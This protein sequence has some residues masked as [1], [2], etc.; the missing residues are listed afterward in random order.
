[1]VSPNDGEARSG[2]ILVAGETFTV[3]Q[4]AAPGSGSPLTITSAGLP[5]A[6][7]GVFY[8]TTLTASGGLP[9]YQWSPAGPLPTGLL[10]N[11]VTGVLSGTPPLPGNAN[12]S[13]RA[14]DSDGDT[15]T[16][17]FT[18][19]IRSSEEPPPDGFFITTSA[20]ASGNVGAEYLQPIATSGGCVSPFNPANLSTVAGALP[21]GLELGFSALRGTPT[22]VGTY[23]FTIE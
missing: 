16:R 23:S 10:L 19:V 22:A 17:D 6:Q 2:T 3:T 4:E 11:P 20:F 12:V 8:S 14:S 18:L 5:E 15:V 13:V 21:P 1:T 7:A 9:P